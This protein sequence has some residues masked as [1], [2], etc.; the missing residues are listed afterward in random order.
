MDLINNFLDWFTNVGGSMGG[1]LVRMLLVIGVVLL[2]IGI[3]VKLYGGFLKRK[4][5]FKMVRNWPNMIA[6][7]WFAYA[8]WQDLFGREEEFLLSLLLIGA[9]VMLVYAIYTLVKTKNII[10]TLL[11][12][13][14]M[15]FFNV[16]LGY[17]LGLFAGFAIVIVFGIILISGAFERRVRV[18]RNCGARAG[19]C[20]CG[21]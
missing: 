5:G 7:I 18:C 10:W 21:H 3:V 8:H 2:I 6:I 13:V 17:I 1:L 16:I 12:T 20:S 19:T 15:W 4:Y 9:P 14:I 11:T